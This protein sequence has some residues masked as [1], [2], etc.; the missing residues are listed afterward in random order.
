MFSSLAFS[1]V[2]MYLLKIYL[3]V[4]LFFF[5]LASWDW[6]GVALLLRDGVFDSTF[7]DS[8]FLGDFRKVNRTGN[9]A[10]SI[11]FRCSSSK[12]NIRTGSTY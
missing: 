11:F 2:L 6:M 8:S 5:G 1:I 3:F 12:K 7:F 9:A 10:W 4:D